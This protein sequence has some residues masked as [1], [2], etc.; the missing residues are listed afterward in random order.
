MDPQQDNL[1]KS[2]EDYLEAVLFVEQRY[3]KIRSVDVANLLGVSRPS[4]N[5]ALRI[6]QDKGYI[7]KPDYGTVTI[8]PLGRERAESVARRHGALTRLLVDVLG[9][10]ADIAQRDACKIEHDIS[11]ETLERLEA[12]LQRYDRKE[13]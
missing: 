8:T 9:V 13:D 4:V 10:R 7:T 3:G 2:G 11:A 6:L 12:F 5:R 1:L